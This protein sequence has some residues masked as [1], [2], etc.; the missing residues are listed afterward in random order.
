MKK[1]GKRFI[2]L[3]MTL[4]LMMGTVPS[5]ALAVSNTEDPAAETQTDAPTASEVEDAIFGEDESIKQTAAEDGAA[6]KAI[7]VKNASPAMKSA[8]PVLRAS[9]EGNATEISDADRLNDII[10]DLNENGGSKTILLTDDVSLLNNARIALSNGEL[11]I[12]GGGHS[13]KA[14]FSISGSAVLNLGSEGYNEELTLTSSRTDC[15]VFDV[16]G[17]SVLNIYD[18]VTIGPCNGTGTAGGVQAHSLSQVNMYGGTITG[19][20]SISVSGGVY[21]DGNAV[22]NMYGGTIKDCTGVEGGAVG[23]S[24]G[25]PIGGTGESSVQFNMSGG[26]IENCTDQYIGG[27]AVC[28]FTVYPVVFNMTGGEIKNCTAASSRYGYGGGVLIYATGANTNVQLSAGTISGN[29]AKY[30]GGIMV[31]VGNV[32]I[33]DGFG[34]HNNSATDGGD[35]I[36]NNG[37]NVTLGTADTSAVLQGCEHGITGWF[38]DAESRWSYKNCTDEEDYLEPFTHT[39]ELYTEEYGL[40]AAH[41]IPSYT[42]T[43]VNYDGSVLE[44]DTEVPYGTMPTYD[45]TTPVKTATDQYTYTFDGWT[46]T[47]DEVT[48]DA[49]YTAVYSETL[50]AYTVT[51]IDDDGTVLET[52]T[53]VP[54]GTTPTYDGTTPVKTATD[55]YTYTFDGWTPTVDEATGDATYTAVYSK[56]LNTYTVTWLDDDGSVLKID[57]EVPYGTTPA[58]DKA[59]PTKAATDKYTYTFD[60]WTL[61]VDEVTGNVTY[62][63]VY[64]ETSSDTS[65]SNTPKTGDDGRLVLWIAMMILSAAGLCG[66]AF[67]DRK[68]RYVPKH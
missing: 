24:G 9:G 8:A 54:Y 4:L 47:V 27:G 20:T 44:T 13:L 50:N 35:D 60:G 23:L 30:G 3:L 1:T 29:S 31:F 40:K 55:Q 46:P 6:D 39:G 32:S 51:W 7:A 36:Y 22:F 5:Q 10:S 17:T 41:G 52:D 61:S 34:L 18:G 53:E 38:E 16:T 56:A 68:R 59:T 57:T 48:G 65:D 67:L 21:L 49:T 63:A 64:S 62:T 2:S 33:A 25:S 15:G 19:C 26:T 58:Y 28:A 12:L 37:A 43:W 66:V 42:V 14:A 45:G 11:T